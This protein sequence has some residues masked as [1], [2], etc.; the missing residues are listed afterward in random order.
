MALELCLHLALFAGAELKIIVGSTFLTAGQ[1]LKTE[2]RI[3]GPFRLMKK[4]ASLFVQTR[5]MVLM[6]I[7]ADVFE[8]MRWHPQ[9]DN[10]IAHRDPFDASLDV[11]GKPGR[12]ISEDT[13]ATFS[14]FALHPA[15]H[16]F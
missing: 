11:M 8:L 12:P 15:L 6:K 5:E 1:A 10:F 2:A 4:A 9:K 14:T 7:T 16:A 3:G 13:C